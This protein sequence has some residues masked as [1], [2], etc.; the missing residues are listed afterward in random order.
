MSEKKQRP[1][2]AKNPRVE[3]RLASLFTGLEA[4]KVD[5]E[6]APSQLPPVAP[7]MEAE[8]PYEERLPHA[9]A[10][11]PPL[12]PPTAP[13]TPSPQEPQAV[14]AGQ[15]PG[16]GSHRAQEKVESVAP[17][18]EAPIPA[19]AWPQPPAASSTPRPFGR[20][21]GFE[22]LPGGDEDTVRPAETIRT[23]AGYTSLMHGG[24][25]LDG[26][27]YRPEPQPG[28]PSVLALSVPFNDPALDLDDAS[29]TSLL[30]EI[31]D[32]SPERVWSDDERMLVEQVADQLTLS[33]ENARLFEQTRRRN[34]ELDTLNQIISTASHTLDTNEMLAQVLDQV[35]NLLAPDSS[36]LEAGLVSMVD[37]STGRLSLIA[38]RNLP[39]ALMNRI[40]QG[41]EGTLCELVY[42]K[43]GMIFLADMARDKVEIDTSSL[44]A[45]GLRSYLGTPIL[46]KNKILGTICTFSSLPRSPQDSAEAL[47]LSVGQQIGVAIENANL[48]EQTR[49]RNEELDALNRI[50]GS[51]SRT[52][53]T[54]E[55]LAEVLDQVLAVLGSDDTA[56]QA[57]LISLLHPR[58]GKLYLAVH[59]H[60]PEPLA[61]KLSNGLENTLC[62]LVYKRQESIFL[63]SLSDA[64]IEIDPSGLLK[65]G[66]NAYLGAPLVS[67]GRI[68]GTICTFSWAERSPQDTFITLL[69]LVGQQVGVALENASLF[70]TT[71]SALAE[72]ETMYQ[73]SAS[74]NAAQSYGDILA[75]LRH[76]TML[77][78]GSR[79]QMLM[80]HFDTPWVRARHNQPEQIPQAMNILTQWASFPNPERIP[81][82][83]EM[84]PFEW[85]VR[86]FRPDT[87]L[88][89]EDVESSHLL[90]AHTRN[91]AEHYDFRSMILLPLV[92]AGQWRGFIGAYYGEVNHFPEAERRRMMSL[93]GQAAVTME[94]LRLIDE[95][96]R[97]AGQLQTAAEIAR[98]TSSTLALEHLLARTVNLL[99]DRF[100]YYHTSIFLLDEDERYAIVRE[101]TGDA[102]AAMKNSGHRLP[103]GSHTVIGYVTGEGQPLVVN[104]VNL[105]GAPIPYQPNPLLPLTQS[106]LGVPLR[107]GERVIGA[108]DVQSTEA[109][110]FTPEDISVLQTLGDQIAV[111]VDNARSYELAQ[112]AV[113]EIREA[114]K[115]KTQFLANMSHELR[116]PLNSIIGFS[117]V[118]LKGIDGPVND[119]QQQDLS[120]IY[121]SG[122]HLLGLI[123]DVLDLSKIEAG[124]LEL[125][126]EK[127]VNLVEIIASVMSTMTGLV[128]DK[129]IKL[130]KEI[131]PDLPTIRADPM[132]VRQVLIN[133]L[134]NAAKFTDEG[135]IIIRATNDQI[136]GRPAVRL[137]VTDSGPGISDEDKKKLFMPFSQVDASPTRKTGGTGLGLSI[138]R[139][140]CD[141]HGG[142]IGV[143]SVVGEGST[144]W[145]ILPVIQQGV[146]EQ[147]P[148]APETAVA[149]LPADS[150]P[151][152]QAASVEPPA[153]SVEALATPAKTP[154][155]LETESAPTETPQAI[156]EPQASPE[157]PP[158]GN[159]HETE[160]AASLPRA[161]KS[162][163]LPAILCVDNDL[164]VI[165]LYE[166]YLSNHGYRVLA[167]TDLTQVT[168][169][170]REVRPL[171]ITLDVAMQIQS[172]QN[173]D[174]F[175]VL[176]AL[177]TNPLTSNVPVVV[178]SLLSG[179]PGP[180]GK[181]E[182][183]EKALEMGAA[184]YL[185][186]PILEEDLA[187]AIR[188]VCQAEG[189]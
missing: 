186:K 77:G 66:I 164:R 32:E 159:G 158:G 120:A 147:E 125:A 82:S 122:Q 153:A 101:A 151:E 94:N 139:H 141:M 167:L 38:H 14:Q 20:S 184:D 111:G 140:L 113:E 46:A 168:T 56:Q 133:L 13:K 80:A 185:M 74:L 26:P 79:T 121:N 63:P 108:L 53:D 15:R 112:K 31:L 134:S 119:M 90:D 150:A 41:L 180:S 30:L 81:A 10:A 34:E 44:L 107:I 165:H 12:E 149:N 95:T 47:L 117:R 126:F 156:I 91:W 25:V 36:S 2:F 60:L 138:C 182:Y 105:P 130:L 69:Q 17:V 171:A 24:L 85:M 170:A 48:F 45:M 123:N 5:Q 137:S 23:P 61:V 188:Q 75:T 50:I 33:L 29:A 114:D 43:G 86:H 103:V 55:M 92:V 142:K 11:P 104:D 9:Q 183:V 1:S 97:R 96:R 157:S 154:D 22:A 131:V 37:P 136:K 3:D 35:L 88:Y 67:K 115:M 87:P 64:E 52:L 173:L 54:N 118:I 19:P 145:F 27:A 155:K 49:R 181:P 58:T 144:F 162:Q 127:D 57:G 4:E 39:P 178:C 21:F 161:R 18:D 68:L 62:E 7:V 72:T 73:A 152:A 129:P 179:A 51:A 102:G 160:N 78:R 93:A 76:H 16:N 143:D 166:R 42:K 189:E 124:K 8:P 28:E 146:I 84:R 109:N 128:K 99:R 169:V 176:A 98:D 70:E 172:P 106:E 148:V 40:N 59:Q 71:Q 132:K 174:G 89:V 110:A 175:Q 177:K 83:L 187:Q 163:G 6:A 100:D 135:A 65:L 116:T